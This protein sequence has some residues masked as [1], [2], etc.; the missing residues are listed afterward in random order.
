M[1]ACSGSAQPAP[2]TTPAPPPV[3]TTT[4]TAP[5]DVLQAALDDWF[6]ATGAG[7]SAAVRW[8]DG[9]TWMGTSGFADRSAGR[10]LDTGDTFRIGSIAKTFTAV[11]AMQL[12]EEGAMD[13]DE[14]VA[15]HLPALGL[16]PAI[17]VAHLLGH[18]SGIR[19]GVEPG[20]GSHG[21]DGTRLVVERS[22]EAGPLFEPGTHYDYSNTNYLIAGLLVEAVTGATAHGEI[23]RRAIEPLGLASTFMAGYE[24]GTVTA[25]PDGDPGREEDYE[26]TDWLAWTA[27]AMAATPEDLVGFGSAL[28]S[29]DLM[30]P[31]SLQAMVTPSDEIGEG[32]EYGLGVQVVE[33]DGRP[34]LGHY[35]GIPG[36]LSALLHFPDTGI[37]MAVASNAW[38]AGDLW[39]LVDGLASLA[40]R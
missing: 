32:A 16:D 4:T 14:P 25:A 37:T 30:A 18:R 38:G 36:Y 9:T 27:G 11:V 31:G 20:A 29:G 8:A 34:A 7:V 22:I 40:H 24:A 6:D 2:T 26:G 13:L 19:D 33:A 1:S 39:E 3:P 23:R 12:I 35:G 28:F 17:T 15:E 10:L 5:G 21:P